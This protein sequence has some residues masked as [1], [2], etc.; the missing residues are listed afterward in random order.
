MNFLAMFI[1]LPYLSAKP[2]IFGIYSVCISIAIFLAYADLGFIGAGQKYAAE[3]LVRE[4]KNQEAQV[5]G[6]IS[7][8]LLIFLLLLSVV[9]FHLSLHPRLLIKN[10]IAGQEASVAS[11]LLL[12]LALFTPVALLQRILQIIFGIRLEDYIVQRTNI[13]ASLIKVLSVLWFFRHGQ[14]NIVGYFLFTQIVNLL[15]A[16]IS[17]IIARKRYN[18]NFK[19]LL[20]SMRFSRSIFSK[21]RKLAFSG[22]YL[23]IVWI[24]YY[25]LDPT[26]IGKFI[27]A[28][29]VAIY[30]VGLTLLSF[31]R[32]IFGILFS[33]FYN[34]RFHFIGANDMEGLKS[35]CLHVI[36]ITAPLVVM[37][38]IT[39]ALLAKPLILSW[40]GVNYAESVEIARYLVLCNLFAFISYPTAELLFAQERISIM[41]FVGTLLPV[42]YWG[43][44]VLTY[45]FLGLKSFAIFKLFVFCISA[46]AYCFITIK[47]LNINFTQFLTKI[48]RPML[49]PTIFLIV[50]AIIIKGFLPCDKSKLNLLIVTT[51][52]G[53]LISIAFILQYFSSTYIRKYI[54]EI[55]TPQFN[56]EGSFFQRQ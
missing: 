20:A 19:V 39:I 5:I 16:I 14:Y 12:I 54:N 38:I 34:R 53:C 42:L 18:Y 43:G 8:I 41:N 15:A 13:I 11:A 37:P 45:S 31:F 30:A 52:A 22:L 25:E 9:F 21:T 46:I 36:I 10:L 1:V 2:D 49:L 17:L 40:V 3:H 4:E 50:T 27:G 35:F 29:Q 7:F 24:L 28:K 56:N 32:G 47:F 51:T 33:P 44:I 55:L 48:F 26:I 6:F 23:V